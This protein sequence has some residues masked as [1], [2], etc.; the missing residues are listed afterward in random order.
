MKFLNISN[1]FK[2]DMSEL[3][4]V[5]KRV[6]NFK[7][8]FLF[9]SK[10]LGKHIPVIP[11]VCKTA[12]HLLASLYY[13]KIDSKS[14]IEYIKNPTQSNEQIKKLINTSVDTDKKTLVIG[15][16]E[17]ATGL[18]MS[19]ASAIRNCTYYSTTRETFTDKKFLFSFE[20]VH[21]HATTHKCYDNLNTSFDSFDEIVLVDDEITTGNSMLNLIEKIHQLSNV[22]TYRILTILDWRDEKCKERF[23]TVQSNK[24]IDIK[25]FSILSGNIVVEDNTVFKEGEI[26]TLPDS[27]ENYKINSKFERLKCTKE[28]DIQE[29]YYKH[30]G[31]FGI[32]HS[33]I[34]NI[35]ILAKDTASRIFKEILS[36]KDNIKK[37]LVLSEGE[38]VYITSRIASYF[39]SDIEVLFKATTMC[40][41]YVDG[42]IIKDKHTYTGHSDFKYYLYNKKDAEENYDLVL[43]IG[44]FPVNAQL[45][46]NMINISLKDS[47]EEV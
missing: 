21:S 45:T 29:Y 17:T 13:S 37:I 35:E 25:V 46:S 2:F 1:P 12:G 33:D 47:I 19:V 30:S 6:N 4:C 23:E 27:K 3:F 39:P 7:R 43:F 36:N 40:P 9:V 5:G 42:Q 24:N 22:K 28:N 32:T 8:N 16:A 41:M 18:G 44:E 26:E 38:D 34:E 20:E 31:R 11:D 15:F 14:L 10:I